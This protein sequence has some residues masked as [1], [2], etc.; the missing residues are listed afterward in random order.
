MEGEWWDGGGE[1]EGGY[2]R[3][4]VTAGRLIADRV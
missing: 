4:F 2:L 1:S 3:G